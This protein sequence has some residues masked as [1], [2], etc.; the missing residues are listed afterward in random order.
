MKTH[1]VDLADLAA[2]GCT[3]ISITS[4][5]RTADTASLTFILESPEASLP[6]EWCDEVTIT[7]G[8]DV[9]FC[10]YVLD[11]PDVAIDA[12]GI[13]CNITIS[14]VVA[15]LDSVPYVDAQSFKGLVSSKTRLVPAGAVISQVVQSCLSQPGGGS[16]FDSV[17]VN[18]N[19]SILC[20]VGS[21]SQTGWSLINSCLH[22]V[23]NAA[24]WYNPESRRL[25]LHTVDQNDVLTV[26]LVEK[27]VKK[28]EKTLFTFAG[29]ESA[30][31]KPRHD[32][33]PPAVG[34]I[35]EN[36]MKSAVYGGS[37][38]QPWAFVFQVPD[39]SGAYDMQNMPP[40]QQRLYQDITQQKMVVLGEKVPTGWATTGNMKTEM[41]S[42]P[43]PWHKFWSSFP[44][45]TALK[46]TNVSCLAY[47]L[48][49]FEPVEGED[50]YPDADGESQVPENYKEFNTSNTIYVLTQ[51]QFPASTEKKENVNGLKFCKGKLKQYVWLDK[52]YAG[53]LSTDEWQEF[54]SG[55]AKAQIGGVSGKNTRYALLELDAIFINRRRKLYQTGTN[56]L[57]DSTDEDFKEEETNTDTGGAV[58]ATDSDY[59]AAAL[60]FYNATRQLYYDGSITLRGVVGYK[61]AHFDGTSLNVVGARSEWENMATPIVQAEY[62]PQ[63]QTLTISTG[64]PEILS[65]DERVQRTLIGRQAVFAAGTS[66]ANIEPKKE[67]TENPDDETQESE[68]KTYPMVSPSISAQASV[69]KSGR[70][71]NPFQMYSEGTGEGVKWYI[72]GGSLAAPGGRVVT[73]E[74]TDIT[75][76]VAMYPT[77]KFTVRVERKERSNEWQAVIRHYTPKTTPQ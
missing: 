40:E 2:L 23:P 36:N 15:L 22:W 16:C 58:E 53:T 9:L 30:N 74:T 37:L 11:E 31:F 13:R 54:F 12:G 41:S 27:C 52:Q 45:L 57:L 71:L 48:A 24:S 76:L 73:L 17:Q 70:P 68:E 33:C 69:T 55:S 61:P 44:A 43:G 7:D 72:N 66:L 18:F 26:D 49:V 38:R 62:Q 65:I 47:G 59:T 42:A 46:K 28:G 6:L 34:L 60:D 21:G 5:S 4:A 39:I 29:Y 8:N 10:G 25:V 35:W 56:K 75:G 77:D 20:P 3:D 19:N 1:S 64:S 67:E 63:Y 14:N 51:G 32:L 50:A